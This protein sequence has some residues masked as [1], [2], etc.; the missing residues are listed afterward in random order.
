M[1]G[2]STTE[3]IFLLR[4]IIEKY[5][6]ARKSLHM[7]FIDLEKA[8]DRVPRELIWWVLERKKVSQCYVDI[9]KDM[10]EGAVTSVRSVGGMSSEF[11]V[12]V[13]L[14][15]GSALSPYLFALVMD[16]L[17]RHLQEDVPWC[18]LF[19]DD[20]VLIDETS[21]GLGQKLDRWREALESKGFRISRSKTEYLVCNFG[22]ESRGRSNAIEIEGVEVPECEAF[23]YLGS[24]IQK[25]GAIGEDVDHRIKA[26]WLKWRMTSG[27][28]CDRRMPA[29][30]KGK[31][32]KT[33]VRPAMLYGS[34]CWATTGQHTHR[35]AVAEMRMLRWMCGKTRKDKIRN[36]RIRR[37]LGV[38]PIEDKIRERR[39]TWFGHVRRRPSTAPIR[40]CLDWQVNGGCKRRGRPLKTW[41]KAVNE[42][43]IELGLGEDMWEDR[44]AWR[45]KIHVADP[46]NIGNGL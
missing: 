45:T 18:M 27:V 35:M 25:N 11:S 17:T 23:R 13:G 38:A 42:D 46:E 4:Q 40:K 5:R 2:R 22:C 39:L 8:Y 32:Y 20:I 6:E 24:I 44:I 33:I 9:I 36:E 14:H 28:L 26:G 37:Y 16:E 15:Q 29:R 34:E 41:M 3:A 43:I 21:E 10:Y 12:S 7:V 1:P 31:C 19:A 30:L